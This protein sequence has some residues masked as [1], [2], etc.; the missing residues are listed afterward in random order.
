MRLPWY[1]PNIQNDECRL[2]FSHRHTERFQVKKSII[3][4]KIAKKKTR[5]KEGKSTLNLPPSNS[6]AVFGGDAFIF[7]VFVRNLL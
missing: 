6:S 4:Q 3:K 7:D 2:H 5:E 1:T